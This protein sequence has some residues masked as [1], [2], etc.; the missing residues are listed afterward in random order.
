MIGI[1]GG[2]TS[3]QYMHGDIAEIII[4]DYTLQDGERRTIERYLNA[5]YEIY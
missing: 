5:K 3:G 4:F 2:Y 1:D